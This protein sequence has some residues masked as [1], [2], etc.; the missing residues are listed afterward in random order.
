MSFI[1]RGA[2]TLNDYIAASPCLRPQPGSLQVLQVFDTAT[3]SDDHLPVMCAFAGSFTATPV[4]NSIKACYDRAAAAA[5][6]AHEKLQPWL[7]LCPTIPWSIEPTS[8]AA[9]ISTFLRAVLPRAFPAQNAK[10]KQR[11]V[12][13]ELLQEVSARGMLKRARR[14]ATR[15][16]IKAVNGCFSFVAFAGWRLATYLPP[17]HTNDHF[18]ELVFDCE[19]WRTH[20]DDCHQAVLRQAMADASVRAASAALKPKMDEALAVHAASL[21]HA[22]GDAAE[23]GCHRTVYK[24]LKP[25]YKKRAPR[26]L[27]LRRPDGTLT[28]SE[29][30]AMQLFSQS[31]A[32]L[33]DGKTRPAAELVDRHFELQTAEDSIPFDPTVVACRSEMAMLY[34]R[35]RPHVGLGPDRVGSEVPRAAPEWFAACL[36]PL[37]AK[38]ATLLRPPLQWRGGALFALYKGKGCHDDVSA[39]RDITCCSALS[40]S[41][42]R[43]LREVLVEGMLRAAVWWRPMRRIYRVC[44]PVCAC[45]GG[46]RRCHW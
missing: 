33:V 41:I 8:H 25:L 22:L 46:H 39:Y 12:T 19:G 10:A 37:Q 2:A 14:R 9:M 21:S 42:G 4:S 7:L 24:L 18:E 15:A 20:L 32:K 27:Q 38:A 45:C 13:P 17:A 34:R 3:A 26:P 35:F 31:H 30:Q 16:L 44:P 36:W 28:A 29:S 11:H 23:E 1:A 6:D 5:S 43:P 40:K